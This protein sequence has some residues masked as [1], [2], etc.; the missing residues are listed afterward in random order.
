VISLTTKALSLLL[1]LL[2]QAPPV[3]LLVGV[4]TTLR[5]LRDQFDEHKA[6][7]GATPALTTA[8]HQLRDWIESQLSG[9][10]ENADPRALAQTLQ[11]ALE[12]AD[13]L[14]NDFGGECLSNL[15]GYVDE[16]RV[17]RVNGFLV[18]VTAMGIYCG[19]D[20]S[21]YVYGW[22]ERQWRRVWENEQTIYT[23]KEYLPQTIHDLQISAPVE[24]GGRRLM[25]LGSQS[26]CGASFRNIYARVWRLAADGRSEPVLNWVEGANDGYPPLLGR[27]GAASASFTF[28]VGGFLSGD[29]HTA[30]RHFTFE[31]GPATQVDPI[32]GRP[33]DF[34]LQWL[35]SPWEQIRARSESPSL[36][37]LHAQLYNKDGLGDFADPTL[38]CTSGPDLWQ[39]GTNL[40]ER[41]K[42]YYRVRWREPYTFSL[43]DISE[44]PFADCTV[45]D[46]RGDAFSNVFAIVR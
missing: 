9:L 33:R 40:F 23:E 14:C 44:E 11:T 12:G 10:G 13:L 26:A 28:S 37:K 43:V 16:V 32:A 3:A 17:T 35:G 4:R 19:Y 15:L 25:T 46:P 34:V 7:A 39:V 18:V 20:E 27:L 38:R 6:T 2:V 36:E 31:R 29:V 42:R 22:Q 8:K 45:T 41:P 21:A 1:V 30:V 5:Q 24:G